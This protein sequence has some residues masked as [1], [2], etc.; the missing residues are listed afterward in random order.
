MIKR[1]ED[2]REIRVSR[3]DTVW[4]DDILTIFK[5]P[6]DCNNPKKS[7]FTPLYLYE[8]KEF[9]KGLKASGWALTTTQFEQDRT[10]EIWH[11]TGAAWRTA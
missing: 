6:R 1:L 7:Y 11:P 9:R 8:Y 4:D 10:I 5:R 3:P 2:L